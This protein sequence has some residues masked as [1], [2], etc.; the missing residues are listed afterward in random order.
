MRILF[1]VALLVMM[2]CNSLV[3]QQDGT[4]SDKSTRVVD[5][6]PLSYPPVARSAKIQGVVVKVKLDDQGKVI[7]AVAI[8]GADLLVHAS[9]ENAKKWRFEP[10]SPSAAVLVYNFQIEGVCH[11]NGDPSQSIFHWPNYVT[12]TACGTTTVP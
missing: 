10:N 6:E 5:F 2:S 9:V 12:I 8:S 1:W 7:D 4:I 11:G 3:A